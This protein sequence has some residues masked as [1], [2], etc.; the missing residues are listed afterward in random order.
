M[1]KLNC[2]DLFAGCGGITEGFEASSLFNT[3]AAVEWEAA[4]VRTLTRRLKEKWSYSDAEERVLHF[5]IQRTEELLKGWK[6]DPAYGSR[7]GLDALVNDPVHAVVGGPPC[8][9][10][11]I[12]GRIRDEHGMQKDYRNYLFES[13]VKLVEH[14][15][16]QAFIFENV[17]GMLSA[18]PGGVP[19]VERVT[20]SFQKAGYTISRDLRAE[21]QFE[22]S[23]YDVPQ[24]RRRVIIFGV[25][26]SGIN[27]KPEEAVAD[28]YRALTSMV[29][30]GKKTVKQA[31]GHYPKLHPLESEIR[32]GGRRFSH[33]PYETEFDAHFP[34]FHNRRDIA[35]FRDLAED[36]A[37]GEMKYDTPEKIKKLYTERTGK[38][39]NVHKYYVLRWDEISNTIPAHLYKDGL[40]HIHPDPEQARSI[41]VR[42]AAALQTFPDDFIFEGAAGDRY[43]MIGNAVPPAFA[44][45][46]AEAFHKSL[47]KYYG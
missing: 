9:A 21:A 30:S 16:P 41:T 29:S 46:I 47:V 15:R 26:N 3:L 33:A 10:Y 43:R 7:A 34:R 37:S 14:Y 39:S 8:Q 23:D 13:Y 2:I 44:R 22:C 6:D 28:F 18:S 17:P 19:I 11:S 25:R 31:I 35:I 38:K 24:S 32:V 36:I 1:E 12:A 20:E 27:G 5:D 4:P 45:C 42:E 40:R